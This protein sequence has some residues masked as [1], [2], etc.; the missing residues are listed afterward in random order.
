MRGELKDEEERVRETDKDMV[1][2]VYPLLQLLLMTT[3]SKQFVMS[4]PF[5]WQ[6]CTAQF[7]RTMRNSSYY[8]IESNINMKFRAIF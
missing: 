6:P 7:A 2:L 8:Y 1:C 4:K 3:S 5:Q